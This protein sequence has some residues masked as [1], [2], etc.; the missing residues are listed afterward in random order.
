MGDDIVPVAYYSSTPDVVAVNDEGMLEAKT[1]G[2]STITAFVNGKAY[3]RKVNVTESEPLKEREIHVNL[4]VPK[5]ITIKGVKIKEWTVADIDK[6]HV[7]V[8]KTKVTAKTAGEYMLTGKD[9][10]DNIYNVQLIVDDPEIKEPVFAPAEHK[11]GSYKYKIKTEPGV[12]IPLEFASMDQ[13]ILF[14]SGN[15]AVAYVDEELRLNPQER[16]KCS[17]RQR[18]TERR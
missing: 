4:N 16:G 10:D 14:R 6:E 18:S 5:N 15:G 1:Y 17:L 8:K 3:T 11:A 9:K 7:S 13:P 2:T 12:S